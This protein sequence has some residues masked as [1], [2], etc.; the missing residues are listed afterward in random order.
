M[1]DTPRTPT[2]KELITLPRGAVL[3]FAARCAQR[4]EPLFQAMWPDA[5]QEH[6]NALDQ[7][8]R[9]AAERN[10]PDA[11]SA[12]CDKADAAS[13]AAG[14]A[15][16]ARAVARTAALAAMWAARAAAHA[17]DGMRVAE[18]ASISADVAMHAVGAGNYKPDSTGEIRRAMRLD[19]ELLRQAAAR[20]EWTDETLVTLEFFGPLWPE[21]PPRGWPGSE[22]NSENVE[23]VLTID[24]PDRISDED[25]LG[26]VAGLV[27]RADA[28]HRA[29]GGHGLQ[30][31]EGNVEID[32]ESL[33]PVP[34]GGRS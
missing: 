26:L 17:D 33:E 13:R 22:P 12:A 30:V 32:R 1:P 20:E 4:V 2:T 15:S 34:A 14:N 29:Y 28:V 7:A 16:A 21:G 9:V 31:E 18:E 23:L 3:A 27:K 25:V 6:L 5:P 8:I 11:A 19:F 10:S 24:V